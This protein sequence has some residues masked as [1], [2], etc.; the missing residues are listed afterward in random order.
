[1]FDRVEIIVKGGKGGDGAISFR[2]EKYV[3]YGGPDGGNGGD[4]GS[5]VIRAEPSFTN[6]RR[7]KPKRVYKAEDGRN[8]SGKKKH[9]KSGPQDPQSQKRDHDVPDGYVHSPNRPLNPRNASDI[10]LAVM[11]AMGCPLNRVVTGA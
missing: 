6:L 7:F 4:G 2:R 11:K 10:R 3:P 8:G 1:M 9:G 5:V